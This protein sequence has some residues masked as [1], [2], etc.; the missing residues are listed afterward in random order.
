MTTDR[1]IVVDELNDAKRYLGWLADEAQR[2]AGLAED[3]DQRA[4]KSLHALALDLGQVA[5][6]ARD[7]AAGKE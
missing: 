5:Q 4:I 2:L 6:E 1:R 3:G 7:R